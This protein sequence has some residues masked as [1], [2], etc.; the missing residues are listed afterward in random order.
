MRRHTRP[1]LFLIAPLLAACGSSLLEQPNID[2]SGS[3]VGRIVGQDG[4]S[5]LIDVAVQEKD[6]RVSA[7]MTSRETGQSFTLVGT[8]SVY[9]ASPVTVNTL[10]ELGSGSACPGGFTER[11]QVQAVF[12]RAGRNGAVGA[13]GY[14]AYQTCDATTGGYSPSALNSGTLELTHR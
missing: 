13:R 10:A 5:A 4:R 12:E 2:L 8:R 14:V 6:L 9:K 7:A 3:Y 1:A 11:Y